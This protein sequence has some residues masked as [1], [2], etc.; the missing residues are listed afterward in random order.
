[1]I[2]TGHRSRE[3]IKPVVVDQTK[4]SARLNG[5]GSL[6]MR[7]DS[8]PPVI[9][10]YKWTNGSVF[11]KTGFIRVT[12]SDNIGGI[13]AFRAEVDGKWLMFTK[14]GNT[15]T[16]KID[17]HCGLGKH[18]LKVTV[19]DAAGNETIRILNFEVKEKLPVKKKPAKKTTK[20][21]R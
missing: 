21:K 14:S 4:L 12:I 1:M 9:H 17:E 3:V 19:K 16:Y 18:E 13:S 20:K 10:P 2:F 6:T 5:L 15:F 11:T 8:E 7:T